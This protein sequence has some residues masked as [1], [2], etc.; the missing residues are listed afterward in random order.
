[1]FGKY[2]LYV[3]FILYFI[4][5][6]ILIAVNLN[7]FFWIAFLFLSATGVYFILK[8]FNLPPFLIFSINIIPAFDDEIIRAVISI[9]KFCDL[10]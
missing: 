8:V 6:A 9:C 4:L 1:M 7:N 3:Y 10:N 5:T 2:S